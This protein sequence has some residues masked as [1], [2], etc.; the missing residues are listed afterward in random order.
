MFAMVKLRTSGHRLKIETGCWNK[1]L[2]IKFEE[3]KCAKCEKLDDEYHFVI[4]CQIHSTLR[5]KYIPNYYWRRPSMS[6]YLELMKCE[7]EKVINK[8]AVYTYKAFNECSL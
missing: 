5:K 4:E 6:K 8:L 1:P 2:P 3:R 7:N